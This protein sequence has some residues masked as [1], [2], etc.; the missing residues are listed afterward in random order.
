VKIL[1]FGP[2]GQ[3]GW[4]LQRSL[5]PLG[6]VIVLGRDCARNPDGLCGDLSDPSAIGE[7]VRRIAPD[8]I[9]N[10]AAYTAVD[11]AE[12]EEALAHRINADAVAAMAQAALDTGARLVHY[13]TDYVFDG[14]GN[15]F[16]AEDRPT[17][18]INAYGRSKLSGEQA[19]TNSGC[20][21]LIFRTSWVYANRGNNFM[22]TM[23]KL[24]RQRDALT[25]VADQIGAPTGADLIADVTAQCIAIA[26]RDQALL[27]G[28]YHLAAAGAAS[29]YDYACLAITRGRE[30]GLSGLVALEEIKPVTS[31]AFPTAAKRPQNSRLDTSKLRS[32]FDIALPD[33]EGGVIRAVDHRVDQMK[34]EGEA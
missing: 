24:A 4:E 11:K 19:I 29:W 16:R 31:D 27:D 6:S 14:T 12:T 33:W 1:L 3:V 2:N 22:M 26:A 17:A 10:A 25:V 28:I 23:L 20:R 30:L 18:P 7:A 8:W 13:S 34:A 9:V 5:A 32:A 21:H 15:H